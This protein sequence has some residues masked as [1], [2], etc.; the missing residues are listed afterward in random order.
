MLL[1]TMLIIGVLSVN[2]QIVV[3]LNVIMLR[4]I[5]NATGNHAEYWYAEFHYTLCQ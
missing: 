3:K 4:V 1:V 5:R 2:L